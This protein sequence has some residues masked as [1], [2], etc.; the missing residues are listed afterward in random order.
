MM[1]L[2]RRPK[3][4]RRGGDGLGATGVTE[5]AVGIMALSRQVDGGR[6]WGNLVQ[7]NV[8]A[9]YVAAKLFDKRRLLN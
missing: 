5:G 4:G 9:C 2:S 1:H 6:R 7:G 3:G 8:P